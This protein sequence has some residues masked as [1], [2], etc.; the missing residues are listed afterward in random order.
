MSPTPTRD[1]TPLL[2]RAVAEARAAGVGA[3]A[4]ALER[5]ANGVST[6]STEFLAEM[7]AAIRRFLA[8]TR[9][10]LPAETLRKVRAC[11]A[12]AELAAPGFTGLFARWRRA[13]TLD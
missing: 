9:G 13:A 12:E 7:R 1:F 5:A 3:P 11:L 6:T 2:L 10:R 8:E 4:D